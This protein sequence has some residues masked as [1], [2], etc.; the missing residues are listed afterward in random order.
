MAEYILVF[1]F[2]A[3]VV[4]GFYLGYDRLFRNP[5]KPDDRQYVEALR[6]LL[7]GRQESGFAKLRQVVAEDSGNL[8]AYLRLGQ[9]LRDN[10]QAAR[11]LQVHKDLTLR[12]GLTKSDKVMILRQIAADCLAIGD[13]QLAVSA[14]RE[15]VGIDAANLW[16]YNQLLKL[17]ERQQAWGDAYDTAVK[18]LQLEANKSKRPLA[19]YKFQAGEQCYRKR[20]YHKARVLYKEAIGLD[21]N[22]VPAYLAIGDSYQE[23]NRLEDAVTF[24]GKLIATVPDQGHLVIDRLKRVLF[25]LGRFGDIQD[26]CESILTASPQNIEARLTLAEFYEK[27]GDLDQA[28]ELL[29]KIVDDYPFDYPSVLELIR[30]YLE[31]NDTRKIGRLLKTLESKRQAPRP[32]ELGDRPPTRSTAEASL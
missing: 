4:F 26:I 9:I 25:E 21:Q 16:A 29:E 15:M 14:L 11:A 23:E 19:R 5:G 27:K 32:S 10:G 22:L 2:V 17:Q 20:E 28:I 18:I 30:A 13:D 24:W 8:D 7:D 6:D 1:V 3:V 31:R 12:H